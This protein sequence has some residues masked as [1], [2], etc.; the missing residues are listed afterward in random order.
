LRQETGPANGQDKEPA[1]AWLRPQRG[2]GFAAP[3]RRRAQRQR[4]WHQALAPKPFQKMARVWL[5]GGS[6]ALCGACN[7]AAAA[8]KADFS[9]SWP[10]TRTKPQRGRP[11][12][13]CGRY[14]TRTTHN[15]SQARRS[16]S[17]RAGLY[18]SQERPGASSAGPSQSCRPRRHSSRPGEARPTLRPRAAAGRPPQACCSP[19]RP[20]GQTGPAVGPT[21][22]P[23]G[24]DIRLQRDMME[25]LQPSAV[26]I[27]SWWMSAP[28]ATC[29]RIQAGGGGGRRRGA[30][31]TRRR[32]V[33]RVRQL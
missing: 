26:A 8:A 6:R 24:H 20:E 19:A 33:R 22:A 4:A 11:R 23:A 25:G 2:R 9:G 30:R 5:N 1:P 18:S 32:W 13:R 27:C 10:C 3:P 17:A 14:I 28:A 15:Q 7:A 31:N 29:R 16:A 21:T 12:A